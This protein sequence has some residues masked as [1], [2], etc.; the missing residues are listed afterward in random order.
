MGKCTAGSHGCDAGEECLNTIGS[1]TCGCVIGYVRAD[2]DQD[3][4]K[5]I[6]QPRFETTTDPEAED[7]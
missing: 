7:V 1:V 4:F 3:R 6:K 2:D 5:L